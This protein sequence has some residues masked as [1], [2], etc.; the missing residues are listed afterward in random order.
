VSAVAWGDLVAEASDETRGGLPSIVRFITLLDEKGVSYCHWKSNNA[1]GRSLSGDND[2]DLLVARESASQFLAA[3][4]ECGF[5]EVR[6]VAKWENPCILDYYGYDL[7]AERM[8][9]VHA[10]F[11]LVIGHDYSKNYHL[12]IERAYVASSRREGLLMVPSP[13]IELIVFVTR[14]MLK[15]A[16]WESGLAGENRLSPSELSELEFLRLRADDSMIDELLGE[17]LPTFSPELLRECMAAIQ[18]GCPFVRRLRVARRFMRMMKANA[19]R[20]R[21]RDVILK[22]WRRFYLA[23]SC[24]VWGSTKKPR[25]VSGGAIIAIVGGDGSG[26]TT[27]VE[28]VERWLSPYF[29]LSRIH[30]GKPEWSLLTAA[31]S[32]VLRIGRSLRLY[33]YVRAAVDY[34]LPESAP[35]P[36]YPW[37][38]RQVLLSR[39]RDL[40][41]GKARRF[42]NNGGLVLADRWPLPNLELMDGR[43]ERIIA[44]HKGRRWVTSLADQQR[45]YYDRIWLPEAVFVLRVDPDVAVARKTTEDSVSVRARSRE[46]WA[47]DWGPI[48]AEVIDAGLPAEEVLQ[49]LKRKIWEFL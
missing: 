48:Q 29:A 16:T 31:V 28:G 17:H 32:G 42:A 19:R 15:H 33:P 20:S 38:I 49:T 8:V 41:Y 10:H 46:I 27:C 21:S 4:E 26:K 25:L 37:L 47:A 43:E 1:L 13:S 36:G 45:R 2:L 23:L 22:V 14:M 18:P 3:L 6:K 44:P 9:H 11:Q 7:E 39:D 30:M 12:P 5:K 35:F 34:E 24:R 40:T